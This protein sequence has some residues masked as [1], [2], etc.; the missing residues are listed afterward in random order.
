MH[1][2]PAAMTTLLA[3]LLSDAAAAASAARAEVWRD[4]TVQSAALDLVEV[5]APTALIDERDLG[6][7]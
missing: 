2:Y 4:E 1:D 7:V 5:L 3:T 6:P